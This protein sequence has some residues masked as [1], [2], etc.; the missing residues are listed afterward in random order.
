LIPE[1]EEVG[2]YLNLTKTTLGGVLFE[3]AQADRDNGNI[4]EAVAKLKRASQLAPADDRIQ[5][6][7]KVAEKDLQIKNAQESQRLYKEGLEAFLGGQT[8]KAE[9]TW[10]K[11]LELDPTNE[12][13]LKAISK[14]EEQRKYG[15]SDKQQ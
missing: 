14:L 4:E 5:T 10:K 1:Y 11:S 6:G 15:D 12:E 2:R 9:Q 13:A 8:A 3:Q 7:L